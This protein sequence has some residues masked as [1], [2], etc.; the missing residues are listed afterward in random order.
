VQHLDPAH[1]SILPEILQRLTEVPVLEITDDIH[2]APDHIY[3]IPPN[4]MLVSTDGVLKLTDRTK[5]VNLSIDIFFTS[6]ADVHKEFAV[7]VVLS[8]T[9]SDGTLGLKA[10][11]EQG[12]ISIAQD[13]E[14]AGY[15]G[16]PQSAINAGVVDF[17]LAPEKFQSSFCIST[18]LSETRMFL[19]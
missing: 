10:I 19:K 6:L 7:G 5:R 17:I 18:A 4:K 14:S 16:M 11:K 12:G 8:G 9:G 1:E 13:L 2:L 15:D 3:V